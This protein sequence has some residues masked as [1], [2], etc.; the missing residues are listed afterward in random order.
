MVTDARYMISC[1][2]MIRQQQATLSFEPGDGSRWKVQFRI[3]FVVGV[4]HCEAQLGDWNIAYA[5]I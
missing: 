5:K 1:E 3:F 4:Y 2:L